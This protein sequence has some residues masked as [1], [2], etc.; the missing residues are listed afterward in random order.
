MS[1]K[2]TAFFRG[3]ETSDIAVDATAEAVKAALENLPSIYFLH[4]EAI[5]DGWT[6]A[7]LSEAGD[8]PL[9]RATSGRLS[10]DAKVVVTEVTKGDPATLI[11]DGSESPGRRTFEALDLTSDSG[12]AFKVAPVNAIGDGI[13]SSASIVTVA[14]AGASASKTTAN[15]SALSRGIAG[16]IQEEQI[17]TFLSDDCT[18]D[19]LILSFEQSEISTTNLCE[20]TEDEFEAAIEK[21]GTGDVHVSREETTSPAGHT[22]YSWSVTFISLEGDVTMLTVDRTQVGN[23]RDSSGQQGLNGNYVVEFLKGQA[24][25]FIIEPKKASGSVVRDISTYEGMEGGDMFFTELWTS[26][27]SVVDGSHIWYS[28]GGVSSYNSHA[29]IE[30]IIA[31]PKAIGTFHLFMDTSEDQPLGRIDGIYSQTRGI[32]DISVLSLEEALSELPNVGKVEVTQT[33][34]DDLFTSY[35]IVTF[36]D[37][38]GEYPLLAASDPSITIS[39]NNG[40]YAATEIQTITLSVDKPFVYEVQSISVLTSSSSFDLSFKSG[41]RT[42]AIPC[43]FASLVEAQDAVTSIE[44]EINALPDIK[45]RVDSAVGGVGEAGNPWR[46]KVTFLEPVGPLP[47]LDSN[48]ADITQVVQGEATLGGSVVLSYEGEY[49]DDI[50]FDASA[51]DIKDKLELIDTIDEVVNVR[52]LDKYTGYQWVVSFTGNTGNLPLVV[53]HD[54]VF[55]VQSIETSGGQPTPLGGT[56]TLL[57]LSEETGPLPHDSSAEMV[58]SA[59][60]SLPSVD[61]VDV[62]RESSEHGQCR[63]LVT[64]RLPQEPAILTIGSSGISETLDSAAVAIDVDAL[65]PALVATSG[66][67]PMIVVEEKVPGLPSYTGQY[68]AEA[69]G[70][71]SLAVIQ[72]EGGGLNAKYYDNQWLLEDPVI[73]RVDPTINFDW[74]SGIITQFGRDYVSVRWWGKVRPLT[75]ELYTFY[76]NADDGVRLYVGHELLLDM[77]GDS[78]IIEKKATTMLSAGSFHDLKIEYKELTGEA[79]IQLEWSS[80]SLRKQIIPPSQLFHTSHIVGSPFLTTISPGAADYPYSDFIDIPDEIVSEGRALQGK[81][82]GVWLW[83]LQANG[84]PFSFRQ[85][86]ASGTTSSL[87]EMPRETRRRSNS[88]WKS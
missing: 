38:F 35:F 45:V 40:Q 47:L 68:R 48:N 66:S 4:V 26:D 17:I 59:L 5:S 9:I 39:R 81:D 50:S 61:R 72:L 86:M 36:R 67:P 60:E 11:Y 62:S 42:S 31:I 7:F 76:L 79:R 88:L 70:N 57:Y 43:N 12:Y 30:Q 25:E 54:N 14:R 63:W 51:K 41:P 46:F 44:A 24:N 58:K 1:G 85:R 71:Y 34:E 29:I 8:L 74:G 18:T 77:W 22:G 19:K 64:F 49:T 84:H 37:V 80:R 32:S 83:Q 33:N 27:V 3:Y 55:E 6:V 16:S 21:L 82:S 20:S 15:G 28:D 2:F 56:F 23:G 69:A 13:L 53:A 78:P 73:E 10:N 52:R 75:T 65:S 87:V